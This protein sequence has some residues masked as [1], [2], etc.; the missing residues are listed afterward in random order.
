MAC[1]GRES[2]ETSAATRASGASCEE[3]LTIC[4]ISWSDESHKIQ[5]NNIKYY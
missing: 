5:W 1:S 4:A 2:G 3:M